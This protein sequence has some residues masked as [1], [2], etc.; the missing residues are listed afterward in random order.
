MTDNI[1]DDIISMRREK[2]LRRVRNNPANVRFSDLCR[3]AEYFGFRHRGGKGSHR[4][5][6]HPGMGEILTFQD[7]DGA[8][9]AYQVRQLLD[10]LEKHG[11]RIG[12]H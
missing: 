7:A 12:E 1:A 6:S 4:V 9:K 8:A 3:L 5:Y 10:L 11:H 2:L